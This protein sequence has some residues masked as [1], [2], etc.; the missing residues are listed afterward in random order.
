MRARCREAVTAFGADLAI[1]ASK[2]FL[3]R[4]M[5]RLVDEEGLRLDV[6]TGGEL[7]R[8]RCRLPPER[9]VFHGNNKSLVELQA[10]R[11]RAWVA[12]SSTRSTSRSPRRAPCGGRAHPGGAPPC[13]SRHRGPH[14]RV[15]EDR[16]GRLEVRVRPLGGRRATGCR[17]GKRITVRRARRAARAHRQPGVRRRVVPCRDRGAR[18]VRPHERASELIVGGGLGPRTSRARSSDAVA[19]GAR[20]PRG[21][22]AARRPVPLAV[23][24]GRSIVASARSR[25][26][27]G[28]D[29]G[30]PACARTSLSTG[31]ERQPSPRAL[32][33]RLRGVLPARRTGAPEVGAHRRQAL[34]VGR[35]ARAQRKSPDDIA[36]GDILCTP[37]TGAYGHS[38]GSNYNKVLRP[39]VVFVKDG[40]ER[41]HTPE[42]YDDLLRYDA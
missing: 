19:V 8:A 29:Q 11:P 7:H 28:H 24:P 3:C 10:A 23:E 42:T 6:A 40:R 5:V 37:V 17:P 1:Y 38:M 32:R 39:A 34:R 30:L 26:H 15:C 18:A 36:V 9:L 25:S 14:P 2:A 16:A 33:Q 22:G 20:A 13:H 27:G 12:P 35:C 21:S 4:A 41:R 31:D